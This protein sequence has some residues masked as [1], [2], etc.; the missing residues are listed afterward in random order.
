[1][2]QLN[3]AKNK[4]QNPDEIIN[5]FFTEEFDN[6][7]AEIYFRILHLHPKKFR[8]QHS[9]LTEYVY[10]NYN[11]VKLEDENSAKEIFWQEN[12][13]ALD[14]YLSNL[15]SNLD[16]I[17]TDFNEE[18]KKVI[19]EHKKEIEELPDRI[20][21]SIK[22]ALSQYKVFFDKFSNATKGLEAATK[23]LEET[24][25]NYH[26]ASK[27]LDAAS[28]ELDAASKKSD[29]A[30][31][32]LDN[33]TSEFI[34][35]LGI[36]SALIFGVF[37]GFEAFKSIFTNIDKASVNI[38]IIDSSIL[39][40][41]LVI[42]IFL[43]IQSIS[44]LSGKKFLAC[45]CKNTKECNH[46]FYERYPLFSFSISLF[47]FILILGLLCQTNKKLP[48]NFDLETILFYLG[49]IIIIIIPIVVVIK[50]LVCKFFK[51]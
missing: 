50:F 37:G 20:D 31:K 25:K 28:K 18:E 8:V 34:S 29:A 41:G 43:L 23:G 36:F 7:Q 3:K 42:L 32:K 5:S 4:I 2:G 22:L 11:D 39:L 30:S 46:K 6:K 45:G 1:M 10:S 33:S 38:V 12:V 40:L 47:L 49:L 27:K 51:K 35:M 15:V 24:N 19:K 21:E 13:E 9:I 26:A 16:K 17:G 44:I 48:F 14:K